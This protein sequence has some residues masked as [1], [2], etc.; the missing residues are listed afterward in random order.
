MPSIS[1]VQDPPKPGDL[2]LEG[3]YRPDKKEFGGLLRQKV[4]LILFY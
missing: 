1:D 4:P 3:V 2:L